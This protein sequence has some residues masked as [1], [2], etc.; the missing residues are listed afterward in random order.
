MYNTCIYMYIQVQCCVRRFAYM[1]MYM[2]MYMYMY[3]YL[4][5]KKVSDSAT[6]ARLH[7]YMYI[8]SLATTTCLHVLYMLGQDQQ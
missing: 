8:Q 1:Y 5:A 4:L 3:M 6:T 7:T 2:H